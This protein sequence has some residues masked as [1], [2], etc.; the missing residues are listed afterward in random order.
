MLRYPPIEDHGLVGDL[1]TC[2]L[3][4]AEGVV[5]WFCSPR[6]DSPSV[7]AALL[8]HDRGGYFAITADAPD[9][10][11]RQLYLAD[12]A[13]LVTRFLTPD[14][15]GE[16]VD[17]MP[18]DDPHTATDRHR[19]IRVLRV[20]R[21]TVRFTLECR[22]RFDYGREQHTLTL[23]DNAT[24]SF[25]GTSATAHLQVVGAIPLERDGNDARASIELTAGQRAAAVLTLDA[26]DS[27]PPA[28]ITG[29]GVEEDFNATRK[30]WHGWIRRCRYRGRWQQQVNRSAITLKLLTYA[31][32][33]AP[34]AAATMGLPEQVGGERN[35]DYRYTWVRDASLS[36]RAMV[37]L[38][39]KEEADAF[40]R[41]LGARLA[42]GGTVSGEPLQTMYR[43]D[44]DPHLVEETLDHL[45]GWRDSAPVRAGNGAA[46]QLQLDIYGEAI[47]AL[48]VVEEL[49]DLAGYDAWQRAA[50][51][52]DWLTHHW[53]RADEGIWE[54]RGGRQDFTYSR[55]MCWTAFDRG[56]RIATQFGR[57]AD[58]P[59]WTA[60]RD[61][62][63]EQ[64][65]ARGWSERRRA[66]VQHYDTEVLD[67]SLLLMPVVGFIAPH[68]PRWLSTLDAMDGELVS[69]SLVYRYDPAAS[70]DGLRG[71]E[72][73]FSLCS[74][75]YV[76][77]LARAGRP[78][79]ARYA[80]DKMLTY[81]NHVGLFAEEVGP[82]GEQLG[83]FPQA[84]TH[85]A[86]ITAALA[87]D[88]Q[89]D[90]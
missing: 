87:L 14:G 32:T 26:A 76:E 64:I 40:R 55:L 13:I 89:L 39:F 66:F 50:G 20:V 2:A 58:L 49:A 3:V 74:F 51:V 24:A 18:V 83:N 31:P 10:T 17:L 38:G 68:D 46:D 53:D 30:F 33:G 71:S 27:A 63:T 16:V 34:I 67:A 11:V 60:A 80:F 12:T 70:P 4:S 90:R 7:F 56:I 25:R 88:A 59:R 43:V 42:A 22:P 57:P 85:L 65:M 45:A 37:D 48:A 52:L 62:I 21:G 36:V 86:L 72:G 19:L 75:L 61:A 84:F 35:W 41:W 78:D 1:Q 15:V 77:A 81:A 47:Y 28:P 5:D 44:G 54:T 9:A 29:A 23:D 82:T 6:F 8:D 79:Q 73:T 69:D